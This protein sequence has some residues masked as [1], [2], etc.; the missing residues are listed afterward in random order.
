MKKMKAINSSTLSVHSRRPYLVNS[1]PDKLMDPPVDMSSSRV[2]STLVEDATS[3]SNVAAL[4][5]VVSD[6]FLVMESIF[7]VTLSCCVIKLARDEL[8]VAVLDRFLS[9]WRAG[10]ADIKKSSCLSD[11]SISNMVEMLAL[12][13]AWVVLCSCCRWLSTNLLISGSP[14]SL[15]ILSSLSIHL[16][17]VVIFSRPASLRFSSSGSVPRNARMS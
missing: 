3:C 14:S 5:W 9:S 6:K 10:S 15:D 17:M 7:S 4:F 2:A 13:N 11:F 16:R 8:P 12:R 1:F